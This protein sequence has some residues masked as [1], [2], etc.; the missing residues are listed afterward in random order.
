MY[1]F[2]HIYLLMYCAKGIKDMINDLYMCQPA[3]NLMLMIAFLNH[4]IQ[5]GNKAVKFNYIH[6]V[7]AVIK[8]P[9]HS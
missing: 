2:M 5:G 6:N 4:K 1:M 3:L 8:F 9:F 7:Q